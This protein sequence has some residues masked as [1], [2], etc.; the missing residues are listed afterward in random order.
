MMTTKTMG[1]A[2]L[3]KLEGGDLR[4]IGRSEEVAADV[5]AD[6]ALFGELFDGMLDDNPLIRMRAA[7]AVEK[8]TV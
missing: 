6:P 3:K 1:S 5:L 7:D 2:I 4:S 8:I